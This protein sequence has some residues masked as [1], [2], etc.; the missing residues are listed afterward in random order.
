MEE[1]KTGQYLETRAVSHRSRWNRNLS[2]LKKL[3]IAAVGAAV[4]L[5]GLA[6]LVLP[7]PGLVVIF[8]G[9]AILATEFLWAK[10]LLHRVTVWVRKRRGK[11]CTT[12][13]TTRGLGDR[14]RKARLPL[15]GPTTFHHEPYHEEG[16][17]KGD[18]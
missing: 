11:D 7:G 15:H 16:D 4:I 2:R 12:D 10:H 1:M 9:L 5:G 6:M 14:P 8:L 18:P 17:K 3:V 13:R